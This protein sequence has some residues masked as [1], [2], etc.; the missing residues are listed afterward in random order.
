MRED[1]V[2]DEQTADAKRSQQIRPVADVGAPLGVEKDDVPDTA[3]AL[4]ERL[5]RTGDP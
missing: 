4:G 2:D 3:L 1:V 5:G